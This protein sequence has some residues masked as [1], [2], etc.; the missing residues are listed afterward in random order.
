MNHRITTSEAAQIIGCER[1][2][3]VKLF[4]AGLLAGEWFG[5]IIQISKASAQAYAP[6]STGPRAS[7][8]LAIEKSQ[9]YNRKRQ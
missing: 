3:V 2:H 8:S 9:P 4:H 1:R 7:G 5:S 6:A